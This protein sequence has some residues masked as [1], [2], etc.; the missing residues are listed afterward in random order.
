MGFDVGYGRARMTDEPG[1][2]K[3]VI[4]YKEEE[5]GR[6]AFE[7]ALRMVLAAMHDEPFDPPGEI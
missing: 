7:T 5:A 2:Y 6:A 4:A 3:V 1:V